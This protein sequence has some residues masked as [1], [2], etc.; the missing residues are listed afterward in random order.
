[1]Y[2]M[3]HAG[4]PRTGSIDTR[5]AMNAGMFAALASGRSNQTTPTV[6]GGSTAV[7][8]SVGMTR[9]MAATSDAPLKRCSVAPVS[10]S[11][12]AIVLTVAGT[13]SPLVSS[14]S[15]TRW[16]L[17][18]L[19]VNQVGGARTLSTSGVNCQS[20]GGDGC[21]CAAGAPKL[22]SRSAASMKRTAGLSI[23]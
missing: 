21:A 17:P 20:A 13:G 10:A 16:T 19:P 12:T 18:S 3:N 8:A 11:S 2:D 6:A 22:H 7:G 5:W 4:T 14:S 15:Y 9:D 23:A 1:V